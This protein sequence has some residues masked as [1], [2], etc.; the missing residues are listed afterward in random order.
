MEVFTSGIIGVYL[1]MT[2]LMVL[3]QISF[4]VIEYIE[5]WHKKLTSQ[6]TPS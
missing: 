6:K 2:L 3:M 1:I 5:S 4:K